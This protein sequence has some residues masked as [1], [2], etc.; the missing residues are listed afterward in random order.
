MGA[1]P[2]EG[3]DKLVARLVRAVERELRGLDDLD[4]D[5]VGGVVGEYEARFD[6]L[7]TATWSSRVAVE[8]QFGQ[9]FRDSYCALDSMIGF[10]QSILYLLQHGFVA[11]EAKPPDVVRYAVSLVAVRAINVA[12]EIDA[13]LRAGFASGASAR[14]RTLYELDVVARVLHQGNR[15]T[16]ARYVNHRWVLLA[17]RQSGSIPDTMSEPHAADQEVQKKARAF[18]RRYGEAYRTTYG[19]AAE[20]SFRKLQVSKPQF[21][22]LVRIARLERQERQVQRAH[23]RVHADALGMLVTINREQMLLHAGPRADGIELVTFDTIRTLTEVFDALL[24]TWGRYGSSRLAQVMR[25][26]LEEFGLT[27]RIRATASLQAMVAASSRSTVAGG[28][29]LEGG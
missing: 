3:Y 24:G 1:E 21:H 13:L 2:F 14:W 10:V 26:V 11:R 4:L 7:A 23:E 29:P 20:L 22:H 8:E 6:G 16:A 12:H 5:L 28:Q 25:S 9:E 17:K 19:W 18:I 27:M 15:G